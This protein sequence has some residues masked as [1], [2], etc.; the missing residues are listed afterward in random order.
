[1]SNFQDIMAAEEAKRNA[2]LELGAASLEA[3]AFDLAGGN[4]SR[5]EEILNDSQNQRDAARM[6]R[7]RSSGVGMVGGFMSALIDGPHTTRYITRPL[8]NSLEYLDASIAGRS[9]DIIPMDEPLIDKRDMTPGG[10]AASDAGR[11]AGGGL[12]ALGALGQAGRGVNAGRGLLR[13][14]DEVIDSVMRARASYKNMPVNLRPSYA[15]TGGP[16]PIW[17]QRM[18]SMT[19]K[20]RSSELFA[21]AG[22]AQGAGLA[23]ALT[24]GNPTAVMAGEMA[25][26]MLNLASIAYNIGRKVSGTGRNL[27]AMLSRTGQN[28]IAA[29]AIVDVATTIARRTDG[30]DRDK[31]QI[32]QDLIDSLSRAIDSLPEGV[33]NEFTA[34]QI[35]NHPALVAVENRIV[36]QM[37][38]ENA[39]MR[40]NTE[41]GFRR[42]RELADT[43]VMTGNPTD[44]ALA[45]SL[46][47][48]YME[49]LVG[50]QLEQAR[51][52]M[53]RAVERVSVPGVVGR[54]ASEMEGSRA[55]RNV[56]EY[57]WEYLRASRAQQSELWGAIPK[58]VDMTGV[59]ARPLV[60]DLREVDERIGN[61]T[62]PMVERARRL[63]LGTTGE[64][65]PVTSGDYTAFIRDAGRAAANLRAGDNPDLNLASSLDLLREQAI[66]TLTNSG[67]I[68]GIAYENARAYSRAFNDIFS[69]SFAGEA[70]STR[71]S[72]APRY[73]PEELL[74]RAFSADNA[75]GRQ[76]RFEELRD[77]EEFGLQA[78]E[79]LV[80][81]AQADSSNPPMT[82]EQILSNMYGLD[83]VYGSSIF[84]EEEMFL[85]TIVNR[86]KGE[87]GSVDYQS[88]V[89]EVQNNPQLFQDFSSEFRAAMDDATD[90]ARYVSRVEARSKY[91]NDAI[92][93]QSLW[94]RVSGAENPTRE[95]RSALNGR[96]PLESLRN[97][98][99]T[100]RDADRVARRMG[101]ERINTEAAQEGLKYSIMQYAVREA[102]R[103]IGKDKPIS[104][105]RLNEVL[106]SPIPDGEGGRSLID[107]MYVQG[108]V[109]Q[110]QQDG[111]RQLIDIGVTVERANADPTIVTDVLGEDSATSVIEEGLISML[112]ARA[113]SAAAAV[114]LP[115]AGAQGSGLIIAGRGASMARNLS[116]NSPTEKS[117]KAL[118]YLTQHPAIMKKAL[119]RVGGT[120]LE[121]NRQTI[122]AFLVNAGF[123]GLYDEEPALDIPAIWDDEQAAPETR[124]MRDEFNDIEKMLSE[125]N[126]GVDY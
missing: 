102:Q 53:I 3:S 110:E 59:N 79:D 48:K 42:L 39:T 49:T 58:D 50:N 84:D 26:G 85:K 55:S 32:T 57:L 14:T 73:R 109:D 66:N 88:L 37:P 7:S 115:Q 119:E 25:G 81:G 16:S 35:T 98:A 103:G 82:R 9:P 64:G 78:R 101:D 97:M 65:D 62:H 8:R 10:R 74:H 125:L 91:V 30:D 6:D 19:D 23:S 41:L 5:F 40:R 118:V 17:V 61:T 36:Q 108:L 54:G 72:G 13:T 20:S 104:F 95:I 83:P 89:N 1:M 94:A 75:G 52:N 113:A 15:T 28:Q 90:A 56:S 93:S 116:S 86:Y 24:D 76:A 68:S 11:A 122:H 111:L 46:R 12:I 105:S 51:S 33:G 44:Y 120:E 38:V 71:P 107:E 34:G 96:Q 21:I 45:G 27:Y 117:M 87:D 121:A 106:F 47:K 114:A 77:A 63:A 126:T 18:A 99:R 100:A 112:G 67:N 31:A 60:R 4:A 69:R 80:A 70:I 2:E 92:L 22:S 123:A 29:E 124:S 43:L